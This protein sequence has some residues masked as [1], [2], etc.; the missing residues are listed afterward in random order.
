LTGIK[1]AIP[2]YRDHA[3]LRHL[4]PGRAHP[5]HDLVEL[6]STHDAVGG[7]VHGDVIGIDLP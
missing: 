4:L 6:P 2:R 3:P 7:E 1:A 5:E